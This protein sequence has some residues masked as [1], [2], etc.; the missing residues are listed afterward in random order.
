MAEVMFHI[1]GKILQ[2]IALAAIITLIAGCEDK[3]STIMTPDGR[4]I[5]TDR[6][7]KA[8]DITHAVETY[9]MDAENWNF[10]LGPFAIRPIN[11]PT[12]RSP[13]EPGYPSGTSTERVIGTVQ[14]GEARAY[15][16][17]PLSSREVVNDRAGD[18]SF[19][20]VY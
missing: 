2:C 5:I 14:G 6:T 20:T 3:K 7:G 18:V 4:I 19:S 15:S 12:M 17:V 9:D 8:W 13:G 1:F 11:N 16:I 10:G